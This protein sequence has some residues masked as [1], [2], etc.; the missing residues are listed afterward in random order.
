M[1]PPGERHLCPYCQSPIPEPKA[2]YVKGL[3]AQHGIPVNEAVR[4][5]NQVQKVTFNLDLPPEPARR[6]MQLTTAFLAWIHHRVK[7]GP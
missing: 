4:F 3:M 7:S 6:L 1:I 5:A 2:R